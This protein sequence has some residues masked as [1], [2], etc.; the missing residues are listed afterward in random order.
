M[1]STASTNSS[2]AFVA[3]GS[4]EPGTKHDPAGLPAFAGKHLVS[5]IQRVREPVHVVQKRE[6]GSMGIA[7]GGV[8]ESSSANSGSDYLWMGTLPPLY[9]EW[10]GD[11][12]FQ[13]THRV[14]FP[15]IAGEMANGIATAQ[16]VI[17][18]A[19]A[20]MLGFFG[21]AGLPLE[22]VEQS[23]RQIQQAIG[24]DGKSW[25]ANLIHSPNE[26][27]MEERIVDLF[28]Q[29]DVQRVSTS[30]FMSLTPSVVRYAC[31]GLKLDA[32][33]KIIR[34]NYVFAKISRPEVAKPF[35][36]PPPDALLEQLVSQGK[37][38]RNEAE[39]AK[40]IPIAE[41][42]TVEAD[43]GGHTDN[44][45]LTSLFPSIKA[46]RD[47]LAAAYSYPCTIRL[48][49]AGGI[50]TPDAAAAAFALGAAYV[51]TGD[52]KSVV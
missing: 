36:S 7:Y 40:R 16:M 3:M 1:N 25:G 6:W 15:Y 4:W 42:I 51:L 47:E 27:D 5:N 46:I 33:G 49:A 18:M 52:R 2:S 41:D 14:R 28:I 21:S 26:P 30:A 38:T 37:I 10:L 24:H 50:G 22:R 17:A 29:Y 20:N 44:R 35:M 23:I 34:K 8:V 11:R 9:P 39:I 13:E 48:G 43:S 12:S 45:P 19:N 31:N 32:A